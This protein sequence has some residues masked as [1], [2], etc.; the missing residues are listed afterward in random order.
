MKHAK[1]TINCPEQSWPSE[2]PLAEVLR[3]LRMNEVFYSLSEFTVPWGLALPAM[4]NCLMFHLVTSGS[5]WLVVGDGEAKLVERGSFVLL[6]HGNGHRLLSNPN[7]GYSNLFDIP[8]EQVG[9]RYEIIRHGGGGEATHMICGAV[10]FEHPVAKYL[11][12]QLPESIVIDPKNISHLDR[13]QSTIDLMSA[14]AM[15]PEPG[16]EIIVTRLSDVLVIQA[17][18]FWISQNPTSKS[19]WLGA[20]QD[21]QIGKALL[22]IHQAPGQQWS[23]AN[24][25]QHVAMSRSAFAARFAE[26]VG[27]SPMRYLRQWRMNIAWDWLKSEDSSLFSIAERLGYLSEAAFSRAF[28]RE[29]GVSPGTARRS[30]KLNIRAG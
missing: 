14:E 6:P 7:S 26:L 23:L 2:D 5:F 12:E 13:M 11:V 15:N 22:S 24:L 10:R 25:A 4:P 16:S 18:R 1:P 30:A 17:I 27:T 29:M 3:F 9:G 28:K 21:E 8:R 20:F 19:G